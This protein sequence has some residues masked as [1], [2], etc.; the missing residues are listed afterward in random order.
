MELAFG[1]LGPIEV[2]RDGQPI[3]LGGP[4]QRRIVAAL[5]A[6]HGRVVPVE[7]LVDVAWPDAPPDGAR[8][9]VMSYVSRLRLAVGDG[10][11]STQE[12]G[13]RL[14]VASEAIDADRFERL[15][16]QARAAPP[17]QAVSIV[18]RA[19]ETWRGRAYGEFADEWWAIPHSARLEEL[20]I[21]ASELRAEALITTGAHDRAVAELEGLSKTY[22][23]RERCVEHLMKA[24]GASGRQAEALRVYARYR[25]QLADE[26]G[27]D[28]SPALRELEA[29]I[30]AGRDSGSRSERTTRGYV[31]GEVLGEG[32]FATVYRSIQ[33]GIGREV[34]VKVIRSELA[35]DRMFVSRFEAEAQLVAHLEHPHIVPLHDF[36]REP[37]GAYLVLRLLRG[38]SALDALRRDG[39]WA[40]ERV[41]RLVNEIGEALLCA[42]AAG[43]VHRDVKPSNVLFDESGN[44]YLS[45]FGIAADIRQ[46]AFAAWPNDTLDEMV[47]L[48]SPIYAAPEQ[49]AAAAPS[50]LGDQY[51]LAVMVWELL[52]GAAPFGEAE[53]SA[54]LRTKLEQPLRSLRG[55]R[56]ELP[57]ELDG[58]L[59]RAAAPHPADRFGS[60]AQLLDAW[61]T[62]LRNRMTISGNYPLTAIPPG[63]VPDRT[64]SGPPSGGVISNP[65]KGLRP[66]GEADAR[67]F[68]GRET[69]ADE[70]FDQV[71][72][73]SFVIVVG[74]SG[75]GKSSLVAAGLVPRLRAAG[76]R[77]S[78]MLPGDAPVTQLRGALRAVAVA[79][80]PAGGV[81]D[82][83]AAVAAEDGGPLVIVVDQFEELWTLAGEPERERFVTGIA[84]AVEGGTDPP[85]VHLVAT[86]RADF[87][88]RPLAH[89]AL[90]P[91][92]AAGTFAI[93]PMSPY[94]LHSAVVAPAAAWG[95]VFEPGLDS[96]IVADVASQ[97][98]SLPLLQFTLAELFERRDGA[99]ITRRS[100]EE[101]GGIAGAIASRAEQVYSS[102]DASGQAVTRR[103]FSRL[104]IPGE[105]TEDTRRRVRYS[106]LPDGSQMLVQLFESHRLLVADRDATTREPTLEVAHESLLRSWPRLRGWLVDD[107]DLIRQLRH[108][109]AAADGW[110]AAARAD[111]E[112]YRGARLESAVAV[113]EADAGRFTPLEREFLEAS[114]A[115]AVATAERDRRAQRRLR[116]GFMATAVALVIALVAG[117]V[118]LV[119]QRKASDQSEAANVA[120][121]I[122]LSQSLVGTKRDVS[123]LLALEA[124]RRDPGPATTGALQTAL[125][126]DPTFLRYLRIDDAS[127]GQVEFSADGRFLYSN[128]NLPGTTLVRVD[129]SSGETRP[130]P[131]S[132]LDAETGILQF[133][134]V[135][136]ATGLVTRFGNDAGEPSRID[137][138]DLDDGRVLA[139]SA[140]PAAGADVAVAPS[141]DHVA[142]T[143]AASPGGFARV[144]VFDIPGMN[145]IAAVDEPGP[146][147]AG[148]YHW[149][150]GST[151]LDDD[152]LVIGGPSG[153]IAVW[154][155]KSGAITLR[156]NDPPQPDMPDVDVLAATADYVLARGSGGIMAYD[157]HSGAPMWSRPRAAG[158]SMTV[159]PRAKIVWAQEGGSGSSRMFAYDLASGERVQTPLDT[160][161]GTVCDSAIDPNSTVI[162]AASCNEGT[163]ALWSLDGTTATGSPLA[164]P[165]WVTAADLWSPD[166]RYVAAFRLDSPTSVDVI[167][168]A[169][170][171]RIGAE[172]VYATPSD[173]PIL[174]ADDVLQAVGEDN[175]VVEFDPRTRRTRDTGIVLP[176]GSVVAN[177][178][179][180]DDLT[181]YGLDDGAIVI[182]DTRRGEIVRTIATDMTAVYGL[183]WSVDGQRLFAAG[184]T[185]QVEVFD[186]ANGGRVAVLP[187]RGGSLQLSPDGQLLATAAFDGEVNFFDATTLQREGDPVKGVLGG[188]LQF[189]PDGR[190]IAAS[191]FDNTMRL[192][193]VES[194]TQIGT[195]L[196]IAAAG[197]DFSPDSKQMAF[198]TD[199][200]V[201][202]LGID[203]ATLTDAACRAAGRELTD[204][205]WKQY[206]GGTPHQLC[207]SSATT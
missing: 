14:D 38:G 198:S 77:V 52:T 100:Y 162:A 109:G 126:A 108:I 2:S 152:H 125:Y 13:Y 159:D 87:F 202:R 98:S 122:A 26:T 195:P 49:F 138:I 10:V 55:T 80:P 90:G 164:G 53:A 179:L 156:L 36:W 115:A 163:I 64:P 7:R 157:A 173:S 85:S 155:P 47:T 93:S 107:H 129:V 197:A 57:A 59:Q 75:S 181:A 170:L 168:T 51:S 207:D 76:M 25:E 133:E 113:L 161:H 177:V 58:V 205:E 128:P 194:R 193:D 121:L 81:T 186:A 19:L 201:V 106:D 29:A 184:Q 180:Y 160:Q 3:A 46:H 135:D 30:L 15:V 89:H 191:G 146:A 4:Q 99:V 166:G 143:T 206:I 120:R 178:A 127:A 20:R 97:P 130:I 148:E 105:G 187:V 34:A 119:Q 91:L 32:G 92:V 131:V 63:V 69:V 67:H 101:M 203:A 145:V 60:I 82:M 6:E 116:R 37:G 18:E 192:I 114:R 134:P 171:E 24:Y 43:V 94:E 144:L 48:G 22:P 73:S 150:S 137:L 111:S 149:F 16:E 11:V 139:S 71:S 65:Y 103:L 96:E 132:G 182:V 185:E 142:V 84:T 31:L 136:E 176:G 188:Q 40:V 78:V 42:H 151:W 183:E 158:Y 83:I 35:D 28:P 104:V 74:A 118:A 147:Y 199:R 154:D 196:A 174:R 68:H 56:P 1:V 175:H 102:L 50:A 165:G 72:A 8:R 70:L 66:F 123:L 190:T 12:P 169:T 41:D 112:L 204:E 39:P 200:G 110:A 88:D 45:D 5:V 33:P 95:V 140:L 141:R 86:L 189:T 62:S 44:A 117:G 17:T 23:L 124:A 21:V 61:N 172:G 54:V 79:E 167:D 9:T 27:L 153:Q